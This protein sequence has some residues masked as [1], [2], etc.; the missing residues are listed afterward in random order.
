MQGE[1]NIFAANEDQQKHRGTGPADYDRPDEQVRAAVNEALTQDAMLDPTN[2]S[3]MVQGGKVVLSGTV[4]SDADRR[5]AEECVS[6]VH[7]V[8]S[9]DNNLKVSAP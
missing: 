4:A 8:T 2:I 3:A 6:A 9:C 1:T 7:G 5:R